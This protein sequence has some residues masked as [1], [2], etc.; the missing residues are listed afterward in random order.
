MCNLERCHDELWSNNDSGRSGDIWSAWSEWD[1]CN[2]DNMKTRTRFCN[3]SSGNCGGIDSFGGSSRIVLDFY[4]KNISPWPYIEQLFLS[5]QSDFESEFNP[6]C[7][8]IQQE[9]IC[10]RIKMVTQ[11]QF[12]NSRF[13]RSLSCYSKLCK[14]TPTIAP[15]VLMIWKWVT[16]IEKLIMVIQL[17]QMH[18]G[19]G[20]NENFLGEFSYNIKSADLSWSNAE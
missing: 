3:F 1:R 10:K 5:N 9:N 20:T 13:E 18:H 19:G 2:A 7:V 16:M 11:A 12:W 15:S 4:F 14:S 8:K 17:V 6:D